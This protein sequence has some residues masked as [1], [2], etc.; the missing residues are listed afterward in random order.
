MTAIATKPPEIARFQ[1]VFL[2]FEAVRGLP[3]SAC[4][5]SRGQIV[6]SVPPVLNLSVWYSIKKASKPTPQST[7]CGVTSWWVSCGFLSQLESIR[8]SVESGSVLLHIVHLRNLG[9]RVPQQVS[10]LPRRQRF[11]RSVRLADAI[12]ETSCECMP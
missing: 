8:D 1:A 3:E 5:A 12:D 6:Q 7:D 2:L 11:N 4:R 10:H 9:G